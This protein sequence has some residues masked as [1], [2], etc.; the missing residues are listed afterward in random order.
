MKRL[1]F[2]VT[3]DLT[4]DQR[5]QRICGSLAA[6]GYDVM[7]VGRKLSSSVSLDKK[8]FKQKRLSCLFNNGILFYTEYNIR[9]FFFLLFVKADLFCAIDL[10]TILPVYFASVLRNKKRVYDAHELFTE[11]KEIVTR[12]FIHKFWLAV[13]K[14]SLPRFQYGYTVNNFIQQELKRRYGVDYSIV[15]NLP[16]HTPAPTHPVYDEKF[17]IYQGAVNEGRS[18]ETII[19]AMRHVNARLKI[20]GKGNFYEQV[21]VLIQQYDVQDKVLLMGHVLPSDLKKITPAAYIALML[22]EETGLNQYYSLSNRFFDYIMACV[23]QLCVNYPEYKAINDKYGI[24]YMIDDVKEET[25]ADALN[26]LLDD[27]ALHEQLRGKTV[28]AREE[29]NWNQEEKFL[30]EFYKN[31]FR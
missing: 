4:Y 25:I 18:F 31:I 8:N 23:P 19:P 5:M 12:P 2:T 6:C 14:F 1:I 7:L 11:Q 3:N 30:M 26:K 20:Y 27:S 15:R 17:I 21:Q 9:L 29:L 16:Q 22:F 10:D 28:I 13:E 24:A